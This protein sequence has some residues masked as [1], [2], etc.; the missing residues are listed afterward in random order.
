MAAMSTND[1][2]EPTYRQQDI[3]DTLD[4]H[5]TRIGRLEKISLVGIGYGLAEGSTIVTDLVQFI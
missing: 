4:S 1:R 2:Y 3:D 5:E